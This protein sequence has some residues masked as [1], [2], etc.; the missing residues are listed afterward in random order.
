[1]LIVVLG[2]LH[3]SNVPEPRRHVRPVEG[4]VVVSEAVGGVQA[5]SAP[6]ST[7]PDP[8]VAAAR[9]DLLTRRPPGVLTGPF[10]VE[11]PVEAPDALAELSLTD[12]QRAI[13]D[14]LVADRDA[15]LQEIR[16]AVDAR[17]DTDR[18][19]AAA[20]RAQ[21]TFLASIRG[22]L[23]PEQLPTFDRLVKSGRWGGY[24]LVIP[25]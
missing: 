19:V 11:G 1:M 8:M 16:R 24:T 2:S 18:L 4:R 15:R 3:E 21:A 20:E 10:K 17:E 9:G 23:F 5:P 12:S 22:I 6:P 25:R 13:L 7:T 14:A